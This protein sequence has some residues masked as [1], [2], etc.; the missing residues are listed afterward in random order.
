VFASQDDLRGKETLCFTPKQENFVAFQLFIRTLREAPPP[1]CDSEQLYD[2]CL[3]FIA[4]KSDSERVLDILKTDEDQVFKWLVNDPS[5]SVIMNSFLQE[6][7]PQNLLDIQQLFMTI[8]QRFTQASPTTS[9]CVVYRVQ[10][11]RKQDLKTIQENV[12]ELI[13]FHTYLLVTKDLLTARTIAREAADR[14][15]LVIIFQIE[16]SEP[17]YL[18]ELNNNRSMF[19]FGTIFRIRSVSLAPDDIW[20]GQLKCADSDFQ[21]IQE[22]LQLQLG[23]SLT[24]LTLGKYLC[25]LNYFNEAKSYYQHLLRI[26]PDNHQALPSINNNMGLLLAELGDTEEAEKYYKIAMSLLDK[27]RPNADHTAERMSFRPL[28]QLSETITTIDYCT[29]YEKMAQAH[30]RQSEHKQA[31]EFYRKALEVSTN[32][33][34]HIR[35]EQKIKDIL[36]LTLF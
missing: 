36:S 13:T 6:Q 1:I 35:F 16:I 8:D 30:L 12:N 17:V 21:S 27:I 19:R 9:S 18:L 32:S 24:W 15:L 28:S 4:N 2:R 3:G 5:L 22:R 14:G 29:L 34:L 20:Y 7:F 31:L 23:E 11:L 25:T 10:F 33:L 26:L